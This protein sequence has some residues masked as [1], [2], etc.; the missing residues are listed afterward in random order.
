LHN[1]SCTGKHIESVFV[2]PD[3]P[4]DI[5]ALN[6]NIPQKDWDI[7]LDGQPRKPWQLSMGVVP[8]VT[9]GSEI[10]KTRY[11]HKM[12]PAFVIKGWKGPAADQPLLKA[13]EPPATAEIQIPD[14][15]APKKVKEFKRPASLQ[16]CSFRSYPR[17]P[18]NYR[19][20]STHD[21]RCAA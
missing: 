12:R 6:G 9:I 3:H 11:G 2:T 8:V 14:H 4:V 19:S 21:H 7:G 17:R 16:S 10:M 5:D 20:V 15:P 13:V 1:A 18:A